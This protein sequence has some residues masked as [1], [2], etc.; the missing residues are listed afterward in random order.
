MVRSANEKR[1]MTITADAEAWMQDAPDGGYG[2]EHRDPSRLRDW[3]L[4]AAIQT[5][6]THLPGGTSINYALQRHVTRTLP[7]SDSELAAQVGK[8]RRNIAAFERW[9]TRPVPDL[10]LFEFG[11]GWDLLMPL[12]YYAMGVERQTVI[13]L[14]PLARPELVRDA[15]RRLAD[16]ADHFGLKRRPSMAPD[17]DIASALLSFG[18]DYTAPA[19]AR[20]TALADGSIDL[21]TS[22]DVMEHVPVDDIPAILK[23][24]RRILAPDGLMR[25]RI[26][27]Q[28]H[29]W[30]FDANLTPYNFLRF[31]PGRWRRFNPALHYQNR[32]RHSKFV[33]LIEESGFSI[34]ADEHPDPTSSDLELLHRVPLHAD[35]RAMPTSDIAI[36]YANFTLAPAMHGRLE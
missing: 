11:A 7:V 36:R 33:K 10:Q 16:Q 6:L 24:C 5:L 21:V 32:L 19:D 14:Q 12:V 29:Y 17:G 18:I 2:Y 8:A 35:F 26:D 30:Y 9:R 4:K 3:R 15:A 34:L 22:T 13:D 1:G 27:Y 31:S 28:D 23:E 20:S 25:I